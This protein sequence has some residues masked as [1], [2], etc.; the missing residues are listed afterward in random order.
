MKKYTLLQ[1]TRHGF[2]TAGRILK[3]ILEPSP[4]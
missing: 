3:R 1:I 2:E 4:V